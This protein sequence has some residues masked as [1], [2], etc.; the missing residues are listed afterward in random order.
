MTPTIKIRSE[1]RSFTGYNKAFALTWYRALTW[2]CSQH[3]R[4][5]RW[6]S[7][8]LLPGSKGLLPRVPTA[9]QG[10]KCV[11]G[12]FQGTWYQ[13]KARYQVRANA[14]LP[15]A[16]FVIRSRASRKTTSC[17]IDS[18][19]RNAK[20]QSNRSGALNGSSS[21]INIPRLASRLA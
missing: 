10:S 8:Y 12:G 16:Y 3:D 18:T 15:Y 14:L 13:V 9:F 7:R 2:C 11:R 17:R 19:L 5:L 4:L 1:T 21:F 20:C 6:T